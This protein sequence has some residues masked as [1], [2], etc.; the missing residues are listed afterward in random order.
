MDPVTGA[1]TLLHDF[2]VGANPGFQ[3]FGVAVESS[4][5]ILAVDFG[6]GTNLKEPCSGWTLS[7]VHGH[8]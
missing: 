8:S 1:R 2:G 7:R 4:G 3:P 5:Q 6:A